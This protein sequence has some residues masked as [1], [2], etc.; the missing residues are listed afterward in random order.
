[1]KQ[2]NYFFLMYGYISNLFIRLCMIDICYFSVSFGQP[3]ARKTMDT[4]LK[5]STTFHP[6]TDGKT[7]VVNKKFG[8]VDER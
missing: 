4:K 5:H 3:Y 7:K 2:L 6:K 8:T 1:M